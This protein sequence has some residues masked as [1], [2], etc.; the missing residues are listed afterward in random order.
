MDRACSTHGQ[1]RNA[2]SIL[3]GNPERKRQLARPRHRWMDDINWILEG[4]DGVVCI[5]FIWLRF[6]TSRDYCES[7]N[8]PLGSIK[9]FQ[10]LE[11]LGSWATSQGGFSS[12]ELLRITWFL[13]FPIV[14]YSRK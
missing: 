8:K 11:W 9:Y 3:V 4:E 6:E 14:R 7:G 5:G 10:F 13:D 2:C 12:M 1:K